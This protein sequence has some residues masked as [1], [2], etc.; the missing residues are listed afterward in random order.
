MVKA[1]N[2]SQDD[3]TRYINTTDFGLPPEYSIEAFA[4]GLDT[5]TSMVFSE[6][7]DLYIAESGERSGKPKVY[8]LNNGRFEI[9]AENFFAP[10]TGINYFDGSLY[11]SHKGHITVIRSNGSRQ[12]IISGLLCNGDY[13]ISNIAFGPE[14]KIYFGQ[15]TVTNSGVVGMDNDWVLSHPFL[16]DEPT[17]DIILVGQNFDTGNILVP[18]R[19]N[20][21]TGAFSAY[22]VPNQPDEIKKGIIRGSGSI[23]R[24][25]RDGTELELIADGL[26]NPVFIKFNREFQL[27]VSNRS[28]D[29]RGSRPIANA[30]DELHIIVPGTWYGWPDYSVGEPVISP[31]FR[32]EGRKQPE[33]LLKYH[34]NIP[35]KPFAE[36]APHSSIKGF[37]FNYNKNFSPEGDAFIAEFGSFGSL[38]MGQSAPFGGIGHKIS[39]VDSTGE[40]STFI[41]NKSGLPALITGEGGFGRPLDVAFGPDGAMYIL[42]NGLSA[43]NS[44]NQIIPNTGVVWRVVK[45][46]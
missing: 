25:N 11:I 17:H 28:Y 35:P 1:Y 8:V 36:F 4:L 34:P 29:V 20:A 21:S 38:T 18:I 41:I 30:P 3:T 23:L 19:E 42:D 32:P 45:N 6:N 10:I 26:R 24:A 46:S 33:F 40:V 9:V 22:A 13:G 5:P 7:G 43:S 31:R 16:H 44:L 39:R 14:G 12:D 15:G 37:A 27:Y 2:Q